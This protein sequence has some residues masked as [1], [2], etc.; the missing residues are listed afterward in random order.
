M[1]RK[2]RRIEDSESEKSSEGERF[3][4][5]DTDV[6]N[7]EYNTED[8]I[9]NVMDNDISD[10]QFKPK[11]N[12]IILLSENLNEMSLEEN[13]TIKKLIFDNEDVSNKPINN[14]YLQLKDYVFKHYAGSYK[15]KDGMLMIGDSLST[16][17]LGG[18]NNG[19]DTCWYNPR[20]RELPEKYKPTMTITKLDQ[21]K[22]LL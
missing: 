9:N 13:E 15:N 6:S 2:N 1:P 16:D 14:C 21:L 11:D 3:F 4:N 12:D 22:K 18:M 7:E 20:H 5:A 17:V 19:L 10:E 8:E